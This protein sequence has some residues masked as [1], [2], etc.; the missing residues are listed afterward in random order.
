MPTLDDV[1][2]RILRD[3]CLAPPV[4]AA[5][6]RAL[7][8]PGRLFSA[9]PRWARLFL[10]WID[11]LAPEARDRALPAAVACECVAAGFDLIDDVHDQ[12]G[13]PSAPAGLTDALPAGLALLLIAQDVVSRLEMPAERRERARGALGRA[14]RRVAAAQAWDYALRR[15]PTATQDEALAVMYRRSGTL[16]AAPCQCAALLAGAPWRVVA[17]AGRFGRTLAHCLTNNLLEGI[18]VAS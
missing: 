15:L 9:S 3:A 5:C 6:R 2:R 10:A 8:Q 11:A 14:S 1:G 12:A 7:T 16:V 13:A 18:V 4:A 17:L